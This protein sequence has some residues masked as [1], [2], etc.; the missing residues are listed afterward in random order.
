MNGSGK[1]GRKHSSHNGG[2]SGKNL[3]K[4]QHNHLNKPQSMDAFFFGNTSTKCKDRMSSARKIHREV[5][6]LLLA[7]L[8]SLQQAHQQFLDLLHP[9]PVGKGSNPVERL[10][11]KVQVTDCNKRLQQL[12]DIG[13]KYLVFSPLVPSK[14]EKN[15]LLLLS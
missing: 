4:N 1:N 15:I 14:R 10:K 5:C 2:S 3:S 9:H 6:S 8:E 11:A 7:S 13:A 12:S